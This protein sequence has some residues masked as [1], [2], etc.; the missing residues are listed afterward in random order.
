M[1]ASDPA[2]DSSSIGPALK[3]EFFGPPRR[4][5]MAQYSVIAF[6]L[7]LLASLVIPS[8]SA[9][10][11]MPE[12]SLTTV[13]L[14]VLLGFAELIDP[15]RRTLINALRIGGAATALLGFILR[16]F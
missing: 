14:M 1:M 15:A 2:A 6:G 9:V 5:R 12:S 4:P 3:A 13:G 16:L 11:A 7:L 10:E 8:V